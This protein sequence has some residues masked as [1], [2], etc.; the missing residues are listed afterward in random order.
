MFLHFRLN[1]VEFVPCIKTDDNEDEHSAKSVETDSQNNEQLDKR[2]DLHK[3]ELKCLFCKQIYQTQDELQQHIVSDHCKL[4]CVSCSEWVESKIFL[5]HESKHFKFECDICLRVFSTQ[6]ILEQHKAINSS[7]NCDVCP[8]RF[9]STLELH[10]HVCMNKQLQI[11]SQDTD[12]YTC[13]LCKTQFTKKDSYENHIRYWHPDQRV[14]TCP[15]CQ[16][17]FKRRFDLTTHKK[18][19]HSKS[20]LRKFAQ[21]L[22]GEKFVCKVCLRHFRTEKGME[23]HRTKQHMEQRGCAKCH[24]LFRNELDVKY[25]DCSDNMVIQEGNPFICGICDA[26]FNCKADILTH[27][28]LHTGELVFGCETCKLGFGNQ[29]ELDSHKQRIHQEKAMNSLVITRN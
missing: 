12:L 9:H 19:A 14:F 3:S 11:V 27:M 22:K 17:S 26:C 21:E 15:V 24:E 10:R 7:F 8:R 6:F 29:N 28:R 13:K 5:E 1:S 18:M 16:I 4:F 23:N 2:H 20:I 25:H